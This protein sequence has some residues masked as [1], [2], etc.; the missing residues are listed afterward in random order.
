MNQRVTVVT[1]GTAGIGRATALALASGGDRVFFVGR[2][3]EEGKRVLARLERTNPNADHEFFRAD[4]SLL[5]DTTRVADQILERTQR[6]DALV[7]S[8]GILSTIPEWTAEELE[9]NFVLNY[10]TRHLLARRLLPALEAA[11][12]GRIVLVS[13]AGKYPDTLDFDDLQHRRGKPGL[14]VA[15]R[16]QFAND[17][18]ATELAER[19]R[20][21]RVEVTC[22]FPGVV[23]TDVFRNSRGVPWILRAVAGLF[24]RFLGISPEVA[25]ETP[26]WLAQHT[27]ARGT[28][29]RFYGPRCVQR[30]VPARALDPER[31]RGLWK[32]SDALV[33]RHLPKPAPL[34]LL[35]PH[36][37]EPVAVRREA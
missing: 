9:R 11:A 14:R 35:D 26:T 17:L 34:T 1:G 31:R 36:R 29:G 3:P 32:L 18:F 8:A 24:Q 37:V 20:G 21:T 5:E 16:T 23:K 15:G 7:C 2:N 27:E 10:L 33:H 13:N 6:L 28:N 30:E 19:V 4:L 12:S 22:V 25:A